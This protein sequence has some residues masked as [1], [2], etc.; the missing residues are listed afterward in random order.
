MID[1]SD[2]MASYDHSPRYLDVLRD[3]LDPANIT[4]KKSVIIVGAGMAG[5]TAAKVLKAAGHE[6]TILEASD[7]VGGRVQTFRWRDRR[8]FFDE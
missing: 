1:S 2:C 3:G 4:A 6:V 8:L 5:L 7:R